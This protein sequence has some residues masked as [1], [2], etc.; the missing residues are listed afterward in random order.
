MDL[1]VATVARGLDLPDQLARWLDAL[2]QVGP[3]PDGVPMPRGE[4]ALEQLRRLGVAE[5]DLGAIA[6]ALPTPEQQPELWWLVERA[7]HQVRLDIGR[8]D[9]ATWLPSL[10][11][12][13]G[14]AGRCFWVFVFLAAA[15]EAHAWHTR[16]G[17]GGDVSWDTL[18]DL[19]RHVARF[20][21]RNG[22]TGLDSQFWLGLHF[23]GALYALGR[24]QFN[25]YRLRFGM[26]GPLFWYAGE[27]ASALGHGF[28]VGDGAIGVH[29]PGGSPLSPEACDESFRRAGPFFRRHFPAH[30][31]GVAT[32]TSWLLDDQLA[33][34]L[35]PESNI[36]QF[37]RRF[38][39]VPGVREDDREV[40]QFVFDRVPESVDELSPQTE[41]ERVLV[42]HIQ[43]G[44]HWRIRTGWLRL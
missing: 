8:W 25:P 14:L 43:G 3:P 20:R 4:A 7:Y 1:S 38:E 5:P 42:R 44:G 31:F 35:P 23:R 15:E 9:A 41:L 24:L 33:D 28:Q 13:L 26:A 29:I 12:H 37:Q 18:A 30:D 39:L 19:G 21:R 27:A 11:P 17:I 22:L 2:E 16:R 36:V 34:Y 10:P 40:F 32:C 6:E